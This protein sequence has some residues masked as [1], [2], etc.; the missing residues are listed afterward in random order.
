MA[1][2]SVASRLGRDICR[3]EFAIED[4]G[5]L[6]GVQ[7]EGLLLALE[8]TI[9][10]DLRRKV[11][12]SI[13]SLG[14]DLT[15]HRPATEVISQPAFAFFHRLL[16]GGIIGRGR[17]PQGD[18]LGSWFMDLY[19]VSRLQGG[20]RIGW[21]VFQPERDARIVRYL[22]FHRR[23]GLNVNVLVGAVDAQRECILAG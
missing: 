19:P 16:F 17:I 11:Q 4:E 9:A 12:H 18:Y 8:P 21:L 2:H 10:G 20:G 23:I 7:S 3:S 15:Q 1:E 13:G 14:L 6:L 5:R 22:H